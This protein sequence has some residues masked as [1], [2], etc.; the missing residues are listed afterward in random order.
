ML[1]EERAV[2]E[3]CIAAS[4][5]WPQNDRKRAEA[6]LL[7]AFRALRR[8]C[9]NVAAEETD[10][11]HSLNDLKITSITCMR[12]AFPPMC[13][14]RRLQ[15]IDRR[16]WRKR[17]GQALWRLSMFCL[18]ALAT[19]IRIQV[20]PSKPV[21][22]GKDAPEARWVDALEQILAENKEVATDFAGL[23]ESIAGH[24]TVESGWMR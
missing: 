6:H 21:P 12:C 5:A 2:E 24:Q 16:C 1:P 19:V 10:R 3:Q 7:A 11:F 14:S 8:V 18:P 17:W 15:T 22:S 23:G 20:D 4:Q 13:G 9:A